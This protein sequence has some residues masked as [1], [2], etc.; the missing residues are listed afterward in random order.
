MPET[1]QI[2]Q[3][4]QS[5]T[6]QN[7]TS[8]SQTS[9]TTLVPTEP[10]TLPPSP[11]V[12]VVKNGPTESSQP[13]YYLDSNDDSSFLPAAQEISLTDIVVGEM[14][15]SFKLKIFQAFKNYD[16]NEIMPLISRQVLNQ[17]ELI[18]LVVC[19]D[20]ANLKTSELIEAI[21]DSC[22]R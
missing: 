9:E 13:T 12:L 14:N 15:P 22:L 3:T 8:Q 18:N 4:S 1:C 7:Q 2:S 21:I 20:K 10:E 11:E 16:R 6:S 17:T 5:P 19:A